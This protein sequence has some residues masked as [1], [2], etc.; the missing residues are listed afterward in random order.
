M[1]KKKKKKKKD[2]FGVLIML[3]PALAYELRI[4]SARCGVTRHDF[5]V[6][7]LEKAFQDFVN[8]E[9]D[10]NRDPRENEKYIKSFIEK[11]QDLR[12]YLDEVTEPVFP[13]V[14]SF[15]ELPS[16]P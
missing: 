7:C 9:I 6:F 10:L 12:A 1:K 8:L 4:L 11:A 15:P 3:D 16:S 13:S 5:I 2:G 14:S